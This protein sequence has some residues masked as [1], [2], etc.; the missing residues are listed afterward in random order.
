MADSKLKDLTNEAS[1]TLDDLI[2]LLNDPAGTPADRKAAL[3]AVATLFAGSSTFTNAFGAWPVTASMLQVFQ[4]PLAGSSWVNVTI[5]AARPGGGFRYGDGTVNNEATWRV[6]L[7][8]GT[9]TFTLL[10]YQDNNRG[11]YTPYFDG[12]AQAT[13]DGYAASPADKLDVWTGVTISTS[14]VHDIR[15]LMASKN[16][17]SSNYFGAVELFTFTRTGS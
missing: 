14:A 9:Y 2:Y 5:D 8:A 6:P 4:A 1:P 7:A 11:I 13:A 12:V 10:H 16:A 17:S 3:S 15:F